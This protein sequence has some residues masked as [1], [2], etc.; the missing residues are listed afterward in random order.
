VQPVH[1][2]CREG[3][4]MNGWVGWGGSDGRSA[5]A[6]EVGAQQKTIRYGVRSTPYCTTGIQDL[7]YLVGKPVR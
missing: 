3:G 7:R 4:S 1:T 2:L 5:N 6:V